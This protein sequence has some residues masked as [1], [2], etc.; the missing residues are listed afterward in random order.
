MNLPGYDA[1]K[2]SPPDDPLTP[3]DE[4]GHTC[5]RMPAPDEDAPRG[6]QPKPCQGVM[7]YGP[8]TNCTCHISPPCGRCENNPL[9]CDT[10]GEE[11]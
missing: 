8:V 2:T 5:N 1:W 6:H 7:G 10:C 9:V 11:A 4:E 3:G